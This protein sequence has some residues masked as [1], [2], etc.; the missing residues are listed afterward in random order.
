VAA[1]GAGDGLRRHVAR[2]LD[3]YAL[4]ALAVSSSTSERLPA[5]S[6]IVLAQADDGRSMP[7][8]CASCASLLC[9]SHA[10]FAGVGNR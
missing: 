9:V 8:V 7:V 5:V 6:E 2:A 3:A 1:G 10:V 4:D